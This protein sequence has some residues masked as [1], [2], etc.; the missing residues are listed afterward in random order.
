M[1]TE[2]MIDNG[3]I[4]SEIPLVEAMDLT[5]VKSDAASVEIRIPL[6]GNANDKGTLFAGS[7]YSALV[8]AG[9]TLAMNRARTNGF[10]NPWAA[11]V[12]AHVHYAKPVR[13]DLVVTA[14]F[15]EPPN[16]IPGARNWAKIHVS[17]SDVLL[18][19]GTYAVGEKHSDS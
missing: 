17:A 1:C 8:L 11:V 14:V 4:R 9:W 18:F 12:D 6:R 15:A 7:S 2:E 10:A 5:I 13:E 19:E 3:R 16:L